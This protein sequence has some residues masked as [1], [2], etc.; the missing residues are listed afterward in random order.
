MPTKIERIQKVQK[1]L[2]DNIEFMVKKVK[3][4]DD[5]TYFIFESDS[6][7]ESEHDEEY[8]SLTNGKLIKKFFKYFNI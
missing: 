3:F 4:S 5:V 6:E 2:D 8:K 1:W 7:S